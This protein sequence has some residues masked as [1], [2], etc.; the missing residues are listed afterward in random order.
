MALQVL[1]QLDGD[2]EVSPEDALRL[3]FLSFDAVPDDSM[4]GAGAVRAFTEQLVRGVRANIEPIDEQIRASSQNWRL[5]RMTRVDRNILRVGT[6]ELMREPDVPRSVVI[7]EAIE[8]AKRF[9][10]EDSPAF[11]NG[12]LDRVASRVRDGEA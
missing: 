12:V 10:T 6:Y 5:A 4:P 11:V 2:P 1:Y 3:F 8:I 7:N 9:G